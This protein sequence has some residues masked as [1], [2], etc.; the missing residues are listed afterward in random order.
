MHDIIYL[1]GLV[2]IRAV[3]P[4]CAGSTLTLEQSKF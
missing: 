3:H 1:V 2:V 4:E